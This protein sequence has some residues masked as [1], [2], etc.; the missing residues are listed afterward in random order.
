M[1]VRVFKDIEEAL[2]REIRRIS[3]HDD[4]TVSDTVLEETF[5]PFTGEII[6]THVEPDFYDSSA[7]TGHRQQPHIFIKLLRTREDRFSNREVSYYGNQIECSAEETG[8][9][10]TNDRAYELVLPM[11]VITTVAPGSTATINTIKYKKI[12]SGH[13]LRILDGNNKGTYK[14]SSISFDPGG[15]H[16]IT[17]SNTL[18]DSLP[19]IDFNT[20]TRVATFL[21]SAEIE[22]VKVGDV[23]VDNSSNSF[24]ILSIDGL[25]IELDGVL[26]PDLTAGGKID[27]VGDVLQTADV[28]N[29]CA[30]ILDPT[31]PVLNSSGVQKAAGSSN[32]N[33]PIPLDA[34]YLIRIDSKEKDTHTEI[35]NR[36]WEEF[37]PPRTALSTIIRTKDSVEK[38]LT[39]DIPS[40]GSTSVV[41]DSNADFNINDEIFIIND[42]NPTKSDEG[43]F[44]EPFSGKIVGLSGTDTII[45]DN[46]VPDT[47]S[48]D[49][50]SKIISNAVHELYMFHFVDHVTKDIE[51]AQYWV[52]EFTFWVQLWVD[53]QGNPIEFDGPINKV[54][55]PIEDLSGNVIINDVP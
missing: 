17:L 25:G 1:S 33:P 3:F 30:L 6:K 20:T 2:A 53:R 11:A 18:I 22:T 50:C 19:A 14:V 12:L 40:G 29:V 46:T 38:L 51:G 15:N 36:V 31:K 9:P 45:L 8:L 16:I 42:F 54:S 13:L 28:S 24:T 49:T 26:T 44:A 32:V 43:G 23:F 34:Y 47:Y 41:V 37:N 39:A 5:D 55:T 27:R 21:D 7:D 4:K 52:H 48:V 10:I 35:L